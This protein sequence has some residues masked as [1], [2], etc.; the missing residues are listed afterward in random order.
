MVAVV[1]QLGVTP[2]LPK[3]GLVVDSASMAC[4]EVRANDTESIPQ[5]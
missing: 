3:G 4:Y 5:K 2:V 1:L